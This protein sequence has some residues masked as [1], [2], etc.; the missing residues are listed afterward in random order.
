MAETKKEGKSIKKAKT[1]SKIIQA[2]FGIVLAGILGVA[3]LDYIG[4]IDLP[5]PLPEF[6]KSDD[7][8][9][10]IFPP[11]TCPVTSCDTGTCCN[12]TEYDPAIGTN[13]SVYA[14][15]TYERCGCPTD[16]KPEPVGID[17]ITP[18]GPYKICECIREE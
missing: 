16:T 8:N 13:K 9:D 12:F 4:Y 11:K 18:G 1:S 17:T 15:I 14:V 6:G 7:N 3:F 2:I 5:D 10:L